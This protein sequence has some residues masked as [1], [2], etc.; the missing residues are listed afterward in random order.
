ML[1]QPPL[2][3][4]LTSLPPEATVSDTVYVPLETALI[5]AA[6]SRGLLAVSGIGMLLHQ[7]VRGFH[8]WFGVRPEVTPALR[9][10]VE[11][12]LVATEQSLGLR[13]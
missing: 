4:D 2:T 3:I 6:K 1:G 8:Q 10:V 7:A 11:A 9:A 13:A 12:D 5:K